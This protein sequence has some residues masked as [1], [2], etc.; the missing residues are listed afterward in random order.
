MS[1]RRRLL[2]LTPFP[3]DVSGTHGGARALGQLVEE[4][5]ELHDVLLAYVRGPGERRITRRLRERLAAVEE[6]RR[7][8]RESSFA[9]RTLRTARRAIGLARLRPVWVTDWMVRAARRRV[10]E[11]VQEW[12]PEIVQAE[13]HIMAQYLGCLDRFDGA[14]VVV[15][16]EPGVRAAADL[17][18]R[19]TGLQRAARA[20][21]L[22][23]WRR[24]ERSVASAADAIVV[25]TEP[26]RDALLELAGRTPIVPIPLGMSLHESPLSP[27]GA[28]RPEILFAGSFIHPPN[29]DAAERLARSILPGV[30]ARRPDVSLVLAGDSPTDDVW[31]LAGP[32]VEVTGRVDDVRPY[33]DR[34]AV[35]AVPV[36]IGGGMRI[37]VLEA[38]EAGKAIVASPRALEGLRLTHGDQLLIARDGR[39]ICR[40]R[41][42]AHG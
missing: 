17:L 12:Q 36:R 2:L 29:V 15:E 30:L 4:L 27:H 26:D 7:P 25:F 3:P 19:A 28:G 18:D 20:L 10:R 37:K 9:R 34:A 21:D 38:L 13:F 22:R 31:A 41:R 35:V 39:R 32:H 14:R 5:A 16:Y 23:A 33:L 8:D 1:R 11:L 6:L 24:Y 40:G 42:R